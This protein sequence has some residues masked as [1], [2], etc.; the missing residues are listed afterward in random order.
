MEQR[1]AVIREW[2]EGESIAFL[3]DAHEVSRKTIYKWIG[4]Y[5][6]E[7]SAENEERPVDD[8]RHLPG[9]QQLRLCLVDCTG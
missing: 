2:R 6:E 3:A 4:R 9:L 7:G 5:D 1:M 8:R